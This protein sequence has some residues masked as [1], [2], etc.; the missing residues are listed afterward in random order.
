MVG[1]RRDEDVWEVVAVVV[2]D[3]EVELLADALAAV[4][5]YSAV[6]TV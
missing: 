4:T 2:T 1:R 6:G 5:L 3:G